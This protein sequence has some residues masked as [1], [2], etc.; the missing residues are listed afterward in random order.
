MYRAHKF[1]DSAERTTK[2]S[3][4]IYW[5]LYLYN[6]KVKIKLSLYLVNG[7]TPYRRMVKWRYSSTFL[8]WH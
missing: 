5:E 1:T 7:T 4:T 2:I 6:V 3:I 8:D